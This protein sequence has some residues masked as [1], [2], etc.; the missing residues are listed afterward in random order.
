[1]ICD[2]DMMLLFGFEVFYFYSDLFVWGEVNGVGNKLFQNR[3]GNFLGYIDDWY[4][5][6]V[7]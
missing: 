3:V 5:V 7:F 1:M 6:D 2:L 4:S